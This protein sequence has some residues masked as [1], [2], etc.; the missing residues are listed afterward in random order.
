MPFRFGGMNPPSRKHEQ[1]T[2]DNPF[3][4]GGVRPHRGILGPEGK[5]PP[6]QI[7]QGGPLEDFDIQGIADAESAADDDERMRWEMEKKYNSPPLL[8]SSVP[9]I[10]PPQPGGVPFPSPDGLPNFFERQVDTW[11][12]GKPNW[13][14]N[15][16]PPPPQ[17]RPPLR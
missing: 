3:R 6:P 4:L 17:P 2:G 9:F 14:A 8:P 5:V 13:R 7:P 15:P 10:E 1:P 12:F 16:V 11:E